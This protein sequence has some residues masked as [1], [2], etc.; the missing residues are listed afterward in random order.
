MSETKDFNELLDRPAPKPQ[1][2]IK[3][4]RHFAARNKLDPYLSKALAEEVQA[5]RTATEG[6]RN[7]RL[8][9]AAFN[10]GTLCHVGLHPDVVE[11]ELAL[12]AR[13][14]GLVEAEIAATIRS[15]LGA[16][17]ASPRDVADRV[18]T[19]SPASERS[20][21]ASDAQ[22]EAH[23]AFTRAVSAKA[24]ELRVRQEAARVVRRESL[25]DQPAPDAGTLA[26]L[27]A[28]PTPDRWRVDRLLPADGRLLLS[29]QRKTG[30]TT[31]VGNLARSLLTGEPFLGRFEVTKLDGRMVVCNY[32]VT[33]GTLARWMGD[34][35]V[36]P[37][38]LYVVNLRGRRN[39]LADDDGRAELTELIRA[40]EG[41][42]LAVDPFGRAYTGRSQNDTAEVSPWLARLDE[43]AQAAGCTEVVL[44]A[45]AGW[46]GE[47]TRGSSGLED[48]PDVIATMTRDPDSGQ[49]F[50]KAEGR[51]VDLA[52]D[53]LDYEPGTR[54]L[55]LSGAGSRKQVRDSDHIDHLAEAVRDVVSSDPGVNVS[56]IRATL[57]DRG[58][59]LQQNDAN[60]ACSLAVERG[61]VIRERGPRNAWK[62][63]PGPNEPSSTGVGLGTGVSSTD[64]PYRAGTTHALLGTPVVP[65]PDEHCQLCDGPLFEADHLVGD[66]VCSRCLRAGNVPTKRSVD[67]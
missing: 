45:H 50:L 63:L 12:A 1:S 11:F 58:E 20:D 61:W 64:P 55:S 66:G 27:L 22:L 42:V 5:V 19:S 40:V 43:V 30:K 33:G 51:D 36:P 59:H 34:I 7:D 13:D 67:S 4:A 62:H 26:E 24:H 32:E 23:L 10:L 9:I 39:L 29:A 53:R 48:W 3:T 17:R 21:A 47:R 54:R 8:N 49:R 60:A 16:G 35:G 38:R 41:Q 65:V 44:T 15:G 52:E 56:G 14:A 57:R 2:F 46:D 18:V 6:T 37:E 25:G 31:A 28:R